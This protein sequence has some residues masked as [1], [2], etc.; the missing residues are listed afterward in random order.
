MRKNAERIWFPPKKAERAP[1]FN[2]VRGAHGKTRTDIA[3]DSADFVPTGNNPEKAAF[4]IRL[5]RP[6]NN[7]TIFVR[8]T[9]AAKEYFRCGGFT[10]LRPRAAKSAERNV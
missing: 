5:S 3:A 1:V 9:D 2:V 10:V 7:E 6:R 4:G 8:I